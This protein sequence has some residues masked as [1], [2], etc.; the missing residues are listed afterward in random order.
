MAYTNDLKK[1]LGQLELENLSL[2]ERLELVE[3]ASGA[4]SQMIQD[5]VSGDSSRVDWVA[6]LLD[7][8][9]DDVI[10]TA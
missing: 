7:N 3:A 1:N 2:R 6:L 10:I 5:A 4:D 8:K 9:V